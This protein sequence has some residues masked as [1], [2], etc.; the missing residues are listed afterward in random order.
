MKRISILPAGHGHFKISV[1]YRRKQ[2]SAITTNTQAI[3]RYRDTDLP[4]KAHADGG[5]THNQAAKALYN[6][7]VRKNSNK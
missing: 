6:E 1:A 3:D 7:V 2:I 5:Y 4:I